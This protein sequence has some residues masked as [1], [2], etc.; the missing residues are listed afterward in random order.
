[1]YTQWHSILIIAHCSCGSHVQVPIHFYQVLSAISIPASAL[2][3]AW[4]SGQSELHLR[5]VFIC[6]V[7]LY[8]KSVALLK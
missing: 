5:K 7:L 6:N 1:M 2:Y 4:L 3:Y 8:I